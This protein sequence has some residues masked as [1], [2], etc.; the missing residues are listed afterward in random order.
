M[1]AISQQMSGLADAVIT[2]KSS[3]REILA[4]KTF[5]ASTGADVGVQTRTAKARS[6]ARGVPS[7]KGER[8][9]RSSGATAMEFEGR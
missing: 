3:L 8:V 4:G 1:A 9:P 2:P 7:A 6:L 5:P